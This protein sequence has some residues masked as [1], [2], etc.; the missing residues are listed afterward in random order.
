[1]EVAAR[2][3]P[4]LFVGTKDA[5]LGIALTTKPFSKSGFQNLVSELKKRKISVVIDPKTGLSG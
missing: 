2:T 5:S 4:L 3:T 1:M